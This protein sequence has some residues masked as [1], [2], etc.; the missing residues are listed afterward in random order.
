[1]VLGI[2]ACQTSPPPT[3]PPRD[4][5]TTDLLIDTSLLGGSWEV[6]SGPN[7]YPPSPLGFRKNLG[8]SSINFKKPRAN[9]DHIVAVFPRVQ[10]A[11]RAYQDHDYSGDRRGRFPITWH[12]IP[13]WNYESPLADQFRVVC[14]KWE[15]VTQLGDSC[16]IE[17]QYEEFLSVVLYNNSAPD[18]TTSDLEIIARA[19]D[20]RMADFL[21]P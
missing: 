5:N 21:S 4:F 3:A 9:A 11:A 10:D 19:V 6:K 13:D 15:N 7:E 14:E 1:M 18:R 2:A 16:V 17:A 12:E 8:G 20:E